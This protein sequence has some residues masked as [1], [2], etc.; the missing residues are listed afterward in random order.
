LEDCYSPW[1]SPSN[2]GPEH[3]ELAQVLAGAGCD[4]LLCETFPHLG[5]AE[6]ALDAALA[7]GLPAWI[8][9]TAGPWAELLRPADLERAAARAVARGAAAVLVNCVAA[10]RCL[11]YVRALAQ[12]GA[13]V[14]VYANAGAPEE[15]MGWRAD[16]PDLGRYLDLSST[17][18]EAGA[19]LIGGCCGTGPGLI[20]ALARRHSPPLPPGL[21]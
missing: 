2:P 14:G 18:A 19:T 21:V 9:W 6:A 5:E 4:L 17:W 11:D 10:P 8:S 12:S 3:A 16:P 13:P 1:L 7:T 15:G 20:A